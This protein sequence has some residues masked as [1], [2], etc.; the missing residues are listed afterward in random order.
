MMD[1]HY[2]DTLLNIQTAEQKG[3]TQ[4]I[5]YHRY[6]PT[7][8]YGLEV[9]F[10]EYELERADSVVDF[11]CGKGRLNFYIHYRFGART[12]G[13]EMDEKLY[14][15]AMENRDRYAKKMRKGSNEISF[16][17][18]IAEEY[19]IESN[20]NI[21]YFF[22]P[23]TVQIF[24]KV[25]NNILLSIEERPRKV[26]IILYYPS[27]EYIHFLERQT[28]FVLMKEILIPNFHERYSNE[29]FL[30]YRYG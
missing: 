5:H 9:L 12:T 23:F 22:N 1:D 29:R 21:F 19:L 2:Y 28:P 6:E 11:G 20:Q 4:N 24:I 8:Y 7:S 27:Q 13:I 17:L 14:K 30:I 10:N 15:L 16:Y 18:G 3:F 25:V 26:D